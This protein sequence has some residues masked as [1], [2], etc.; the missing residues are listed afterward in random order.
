MKTYLVFLTTVLGVGA[1]LFYKQVWSLFS[2][3]SVLDAMNT[4]VTFLLH[5]ATATIVGYV[6][7]TLPKFVAPLLRAFRWKRRAARRAHRT[8]PSGSPF[9][10]QTVNGGTPRRDQVLEWL[11]KQMATH[12]PTPRTP[13]ASRQKRLGERTAEEPTIHLDL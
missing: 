6:A 1:A 9:G 10:R 3:M 8:V 12:N 7:M 13:S 11:V 5:V 2:G 4:I